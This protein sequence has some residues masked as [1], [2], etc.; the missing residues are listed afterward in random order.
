MSITNHYDLDSLL[1]EIDN[2]EKTILILEFK[3]Q[4]EIEEIS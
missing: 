2:L 4:D 1:N 3:F